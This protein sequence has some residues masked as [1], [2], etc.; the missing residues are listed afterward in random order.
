MQTITKMLVKKNMCWNG[1][2]CKIFKNLIEDNKYLPK[3][4]IFLHFWKKNFEN[5]LSLEQIAFSHFHGRTGANYKST[6]KYLKFN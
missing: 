1:N 2:L 5:N 3:Y 4:L 6:S